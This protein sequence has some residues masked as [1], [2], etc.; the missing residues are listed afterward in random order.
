MQKMNRLTSASTAFMLAAAMFSVSPGRATAGTINYFVRAGTRVQTSGFGVGDPQYHDHDT[1]QVQAYSISSGPFTVTSTNNAFA[2]TT[3]YTLAELGAL[4]GYANFSASTPNAP[5]GAQGQGTADSWGDT[6][7]VISDSLPMGTPV[8]LQATLTYHGLIT[9]TGDTSEITIQASASGPFGTYAY[10]DNHHLN[11]D[12]VSI[13]TGYG[14]VGYPFLIT[15]SLSFVAAGTAWQNA[16]VSGGIDISNTATLTLISL[17]PEAS[18]TT[19]SGVSYVP[20]PA[21]L[22]LAAIGILLAASRRRDRDE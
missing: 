6:I 8:L 22:T 16:P 1:G 12:Q 5:A 18:Y 10:E 13:G 3:A 11:P 9:E 4:H 20:E 7:T 17:D 21:T 19:A 15:S 2:T 14:Y